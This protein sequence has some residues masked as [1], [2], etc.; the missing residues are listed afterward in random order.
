M[1][2]IVI[3]GSPG[4]GK[5]TVATKL[6]EKLKRLVIHLDTE[7]WVNGKK[8]R[9]SKEKW[10]IH[11][12]EMVSKDEWIIDGNYQSTLEIR[13][14]RATTIIYI[15]LPKWICLYRAFKRISKTVDKSV[16]N[17]DRIDLKLIKFIWRY[18]REYNLK[19]LEKYKSKN[20]YIL[21]SAEDIQAFLSM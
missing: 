11:Q 6:G 4:S 20:I 8:E 21:K 19:L 14:E 9:F 16:G 18:P 3:I 5:S 1:K 13:L 17:R 12:K 10:A 7:Y 2:R 15:D